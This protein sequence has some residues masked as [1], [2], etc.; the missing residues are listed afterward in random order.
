[1]ALRV[2]PLRQTP[3]YS[4][5]RGSTPPP[6]RSSN[7]G[8]FDP[9]GR[10]IRQLP[11]SRLRVC[12]MVAYQASVYISCEGAGHAGQSACI[13][14]QPPQSS[15]CR[16]AC[17]V[18]AANVLSRRSAPIVDNINDPAHHSAIPLLV[19]VALPDGPSGNSGAVCFS[20]PYLLKMYG[21]ENPNRSFCMLLGCM[22]RDL[23]C[24][25]I[26]ELIS[27][28]PFSFEYLERIALT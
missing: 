24:S 4:P 16:S 17:N 22:C 1:M 27:A 19:E 15:N 3:G 10:Y 26:K 25:E 28:S 20:S 7:L 9:S 23:Q 8:D 14:G 2:E 5:Y 13:H 18:A 12:V 11:G 21:L 6:D